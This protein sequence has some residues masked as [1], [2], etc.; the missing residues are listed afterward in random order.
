MVMQGVTLK[1]HGKRLASLISSGCSYPKPL[2]RFAGW[3]ILVCPLLRASSHR[4]QTKMPSGLRPEGIC[5]PHETE[6][7]LFLALADL[8][9]A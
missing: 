9:A 4:Y 3:G 2:S 6:I 8:F 7:E 1:V 5:A